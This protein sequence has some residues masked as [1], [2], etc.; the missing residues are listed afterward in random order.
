MAALSNYKPFC[1][2]WFYGGADAEE[3][4][5]FYCSWG[6]LDTAAQAIPSVST[7]MNAALLIDAGVNPTAL[8]DTV[9]ASYPDGGYDAS[10]NS[11]GILSPPLY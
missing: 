7:V 10:K 9:I 1:G 11:L 3:T 6:L 2:Y 5:A 4:A 8:V